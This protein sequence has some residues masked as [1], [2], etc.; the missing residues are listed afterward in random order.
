MNRRLFLL[1]SSFGVA[2]LLAPKV[3]RAED[4]LAQAISETKE[5]INFALLQ[6]LDQL[7]SHASAALKHAEAAESAKDSTETKKAINR[8]V[9]TVYDAKKKK[10]DAATSH[11]QEALTH[12]EAASK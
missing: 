5:A 6:D 1:G 8:L 11:A 2:A 4:H 10:F 12:L 3:A 7:V 9:V